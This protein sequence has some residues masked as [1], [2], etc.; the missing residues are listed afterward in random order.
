MAERVDPEVWT[1]IMNEAIQFMIDEVTRYEGT[2]S[3]LMGD[4]LL[5]LFGAPVSH[6]DDAERAVMAALG[7]RDAA[8]KYGAALR[9]R[10][11]FEFTVRSGINTGLSVL[12]RVGDEIKA[13]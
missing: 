4:G 1:E 6:E 13:E 10:H 3:R 11:G 9:S 8:A 5:A 12:T 2:V 7:I